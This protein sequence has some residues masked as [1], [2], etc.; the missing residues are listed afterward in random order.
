MQR[1][2][3]QF[4]QIMCVDFEGKY[5][6]SITIHHFG[7]KTV[8]SLPHEIAYQKFKNQYPFQVTIVYGKFNCLKKKNTWK[9]KQK[10][11]NHIH[12]PYF[13][14]QFLIVFKAKLSNSI[15]IIHLIFFKKYFKWS[16]LFFFLHLA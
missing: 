1:Y 8:F 11:D 15:Q 6:S 10:L 12:L 3:N 9:N 14:I 13:R 16:A 5:E 7:F 4:I 2:V